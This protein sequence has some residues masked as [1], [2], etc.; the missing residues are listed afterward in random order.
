MELEILSLGRHRGSGLALGI[1]VDPGRSQFVKVALPAE[2]EDVQVALLMLEDGR[3]PRLDVEPWQE[4][5]RGDLGTLIQ[6]AI[7]RV[8]GES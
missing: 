6:A 4:I 7:K 2:R 1:A 3:W 5:G 8:G